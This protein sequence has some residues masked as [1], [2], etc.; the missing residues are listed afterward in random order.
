MKA[1]S[2]VW[3]GRFG[4]V[5]GVGRFILAQGQFWFKGHGCHVGTLEASITT[6]AVFRLSR[7]F[8]L[9]LPSVTMG[10]CF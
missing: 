8:L 4:L 9:H 10:G 7:W 3:S 6:K 1:M 2:F 5:G